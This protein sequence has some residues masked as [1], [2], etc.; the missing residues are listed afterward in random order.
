MDQAEPVNDYDSFAKVR[1]ERLQKGSLPHR[2]IEKPMMQ[3]MLPNLAGLRVLMIGSGTGE[4]SEM[5]FAAG[6][7]ELV[8]I[9][10]SKESVALAIRTYPKATFQVGDMHTLEFPDSS[11]EFV[12]SSLTVHYSSHPIDVYQEIGRVLK[13]GGRFLFSVA[14]P[15][16]WAI[17]YTSI[18]GVPTYLMGSSDDKNK[19]HLYGSYL[20]FAE[21]EHS[22][23]SGE[24]L[25]FWV[26]PPSM[27]FSLLQASGFDVKKF[28]EA[29]VTDEC[30]SVAPF[31]YDRWS[32]FPQF[33]GFLVVKK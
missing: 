8:G 12:Y 9:D 1:Q 18:D 32:N 19:P 14:H 10:T 28:E 22:F 7:T 33:T 5:L 29:K 25:K 31:Y 2:Y 3:R 30:K 20:K 15:M 16:R 4:E 6:A 17:E 26:G 21:Y 23:I 13:P 11:F 24:K 27:H